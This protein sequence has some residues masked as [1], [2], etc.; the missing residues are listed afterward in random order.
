MKDGK[1]KIM[2]ILNQI[3]IDFVIVVLV[4][5]VVGPIV[6]N[7]AKEISTLFSLGSVGIEYI[8]LFQALLIAVVSTLLSELLTS[9]LIFKNMLLL[10]KTV[11]TLFIVGIS[12][13]SM[14]A[15]FGWLPKDDFK[16]WIMYIVCFL[17]CATISILV[18]MKNKKD[19][20]DLNDKLD[21]YKKQ[22]GIKVS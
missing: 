2:K 16:I 13:G 1:I 20:K 10:W 14:S 17:I 5:M 6:G 18:V 7:D 9:D 19:E 12:A 15:L 3:L 22:K 8:T 21:E 4:L 11:I